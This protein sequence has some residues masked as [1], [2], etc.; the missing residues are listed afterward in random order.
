MYVSSVTVTHK[1]YESVG[2]NE[3]KKKSTITPT[4]NDSITQIEFRTG[5]WELLQLSTT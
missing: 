2:G 1:L 4:C 3:R 5:L